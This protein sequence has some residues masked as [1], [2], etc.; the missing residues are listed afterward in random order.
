MTSYNRIDHFDRTA[1][2]SNDSTDSARASTPE[3]GTGSSLPAT[4]VHQNE[5]T[6]QVYLQAE[7]EELKCKIAKQEDDIELQRTEA[8]YRRKQYFKMRECKEALE[9]ENQHL[10]AENQNLRE[11]IA[12]LERQNKLAVFASQ[13]QRKKMMKLEGLI[14]SLQE[15]IMESNAE[16][17]TLKANAT[18]KATQL[19]QTTVFKSPQG[20]VIRK[21]LKKPQ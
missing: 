4:P 3:R 21:P 8:N 6:A 11:R 7:N 14:P 1:S 9:A 15:Q 16:I 18:K 12:V 19:K 10:E 5:K 2:S 13:E 17:A 20:Q